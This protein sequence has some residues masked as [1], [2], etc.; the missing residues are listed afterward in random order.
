MK[1]WFPALKAL[2]ATN[3]AFGPLAAVLAYKADIAAS[4][5]LS[6]AVIGC[7]YGLYFVAAASAGRY[8]DP[9]LASVGLRPKLLASAAAICVGAVCCTTTGYFIVFACLFVLCLGCVGAGPYLAPVAVYARESLPGRPAM[10][11]AVATVGQLTSF[12]A[13][14]LAFKFC[15]VSRWQAAFELVAV[16]SLVFLVPLALTMTPLQRTVEMRP[17]FQQGS[18]DARA[19]TLAIAGYGGACLGGTLLITGLASSG[20]TWGGMRAYECFSVSALGGRLVLAWVFDRGYRVV[21][22][23]AASGA[24]VASSIALSGPWTE[25]RFVLAGSIALG[26]GYGGLLPVASMLLSSATAGSQA[27]A[28]ARM[29]HAGAIGI[30]VAGALSVVA[31]DS[32][33]TAVVALLCVFTIAAATWLWIRLSLKLYSQL[34]S[35]VE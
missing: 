25:P 12:G 15:G 5:G 20:A 35:G 1:A 9:L 10:G 33:F 13:W 21:A 34:T 28:A 19:I 27:A 14:Q 18:V 11:T 2:A 7:L 32:S 26:L 29:F 6:G 31:A 16:A 23:F 30:L 22:T 3:L 4:F 24:F 8:V 17:R